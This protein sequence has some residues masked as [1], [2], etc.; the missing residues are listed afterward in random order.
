MWKNPNGYTKTVLGMAASV[1]DPT[2]PTISAAFDF[3]KVRDVIQ[4]VQEK[5]GLSL[6]AQ[7]QRALSSGS[8][9]KAG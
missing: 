8:R 2:P 5:L 4:W 9:T 7:R 6:Q 3:A 1:T